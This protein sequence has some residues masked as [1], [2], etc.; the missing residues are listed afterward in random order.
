V[1]AARPLDVEDVEVLGAG[2]AVGTAAGPT[3]DRRPGVLPVAVALVAAVLVALLVLPQPADT[4]SETGAL[5]IGVDAWPARGPRADDDGLLRAATSAWRAAGAQGEVAAPG[6]VVEPL[7][8][9]EADGA[10]DVVL[11][12]RTSDGLLLV[13]AGT[14]RSDGTVRIQAVERAIGEPVALVL[15]AGGEPRLLVAPPRDEG[16]TL[17]VRKRDSLWQEVY[18]DEH[19]LSAPVRGLSSRL[20]PVLGIMARTGTE[21]GLVQTHLITEQSLLPGS[22]PAIVTTAAWGASGLPSTEEFDAALVALRG[23]PEPTKRVAVLAET[24]SGVGRVVLA[25]VADPFTGETR[26]RLVKSDGSGRVELGASP[27]VS[28]TLAVGLAPLGGGRLMV[29]AG[30]APSV[31]RVEVRTGDGQTLV[32]G[33]GP[34]SVVL[35]APAPAELVVLGK[36]TNGSVVATLRVDVAPELARADN[37]VGSSTARWLR[38]RRGRG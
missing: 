34:T 4:S 33:L 30:A 36:R 31:P 19:G 5:R 10:V 1:P 29:V 24:R 25:E 3:G 23:I 2:A 21:R 12:S 11:R 13:A 14:G 28:S 35:P 17:L 22:A 20:P 15:P 18:V 32:D 26:H 7:Y 16:L 37:D 9:G 38:E 8:L 27:T 6:R